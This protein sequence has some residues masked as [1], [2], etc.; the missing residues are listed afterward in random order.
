MMSVAAASKHVE[1]AWAYVKWTT[2]REFSKMRALEGLGGPTGMPSVWHDPDIL[3]KIP[4]WEEWAKIMDRVG[5]NYIAANLRGR[6]L[7]DAFNNGMQ[8]IWLNKIG[9]DEGVSKVAKAIQ[10]VLDKPPLKLV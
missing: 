10:D 8:E 9:V 3:A 2:S 5:P 4:E 6:E 1:E 7:E